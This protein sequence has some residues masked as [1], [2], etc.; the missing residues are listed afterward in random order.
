MKSL[1]LIIDKS[2]EHQETEIHI[3][4]S[5]VDK[6][7]KEIIDLVKNRQVTLPVQKDGATSVIPISS[8]FYLESVDEKTFVYTSGDVYSAGIKLYEAE[9][10][11]RDTSFVRISKACIL[12]IDYL[13]GVRVMINGKMEAALDNGEKLIINRHYVPGFKKKFGM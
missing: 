9:K 4:C 6:T 10:I 7:V 5:T 13:T 3:K 8:V 12:N 1:K 11:L 2:P